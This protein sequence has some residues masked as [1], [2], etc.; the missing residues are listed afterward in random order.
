MRAIMF[1]GQGAQRLGMGVDLFKDFPE[2][3]RTADQMLGYSIR[4][5]CTDGPLDRL[6]QTGFT[7][8]APAT[9]AGKNAARCRA[10]PWRCAFRHCQ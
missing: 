3:T 7:Q 6:T 8:P 9:S 2:L 10:G 5:L 4:S 1:P